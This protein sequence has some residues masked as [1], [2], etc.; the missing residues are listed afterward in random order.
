MRYLDAPVPRYPPKS[1]LLGESGRV[2]VRVLVDA[3][4]LPSQ[5]AIAKSSGY[6]RLDEA[7]LSAVRAARFKPY[8]ENGQPQVFWVVIP[9]IFELEN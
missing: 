7:A 1:K 4:G 2:H 5:A 9:L 8:T 6:G 3:A